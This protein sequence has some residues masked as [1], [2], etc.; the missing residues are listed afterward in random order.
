MKKQKLR[1]YKTEMTKNLKT[2]KLENWSRKTKKFKSNSR[3]WFW[4]KGSSVEIIFNQIFS[5]VPNQ[6]PRS[7]T[8]PLII[9][10]QSAR[11]LYMVNGHEPMKA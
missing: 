1:N 9:K 11:R 5:K 6:V 3:N 10:A 4:G 8:L 7:S 2:E